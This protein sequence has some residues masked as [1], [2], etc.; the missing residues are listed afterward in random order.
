MNLF[1][2]KPNEK[3]YYFAITDVLNGGNFEVVFI[4]NKLPGEWVYDSKSNT[5]KRADIDSVEEHNVLVKQLCDSFVDETVLEKLDLMLRSQV[6]IKDNREV[7]TKVKY[8]IT[9]T[10]DGGK[11]I[12][13]I[14]HKI[15]FYFGVNGEFKGMR[16]W[17]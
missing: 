2:I 7:W 8:D 4:K 5:I 3:E 12:N 11:M 15:A 17:K 13:V 1:Y 9:D 6:E 14:T 16:S 10:D